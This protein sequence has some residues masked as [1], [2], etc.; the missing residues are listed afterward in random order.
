MTNTKELILTLK[1]VREARKISYDKIIQMIKDNGDYPVVK[2][3]LSRLFGEGSEKKS[4]SYENVLRPVAK[5]L[6]DIETIEEDDD[7]YTRGFK[8]I[9]NFKKELLFEY[10]KQIEELKEEIREVEQ[11]EKAK[12]HEKLEKESATFQKNLA[13]LNRQIEL[14]DHR[15][16]HLLD[17]NEKLLN[18]LLQC[19]RCKQLSGDEV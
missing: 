18:Q 2:S 3:T 6:L 16:D 9:I 17:A 1:E 4:F 13:F 15:I 8:S 10:E 11:H 12:Y 5:V 7:T 14:K 19:H